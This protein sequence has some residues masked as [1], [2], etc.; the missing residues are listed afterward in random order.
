MSKRWQKFDPTARWDC[1]D[2]P[3]CYVIYRGGVIVYVGQSESIRRRLT[4]YRFQNRP[5]ADDMFSGHTRTP[6]GEWRWAEGKITGKVFY[7]RK[8]GE[9]LMVE[10][11]LI[12]RIKPLLNRRGIG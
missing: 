3:G 5:G 2:A 10:A 1:R 6:W 7:A 11:R 4:D 12:R 9:Q 8:F